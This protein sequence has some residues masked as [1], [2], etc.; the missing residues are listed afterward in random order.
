MVISLLRICCSSS[1]GSGL[2]MK[3]KKIIKNTKY[4]NSDVWK[5][6]NITKMTDTQGEGGMVAFV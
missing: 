6:M 3:E 5:R 2:I 4:I 1:L